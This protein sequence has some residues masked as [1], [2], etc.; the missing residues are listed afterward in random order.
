MEITNHTIVNVCS[1]IPSKI[2]ATTSSEDY[3]FEPCLTDNPIVLPMAATAIKEIHSKS[4]IFADG[5]L[6]FEPDVKQDMYN[7]LKIK[8]GEKILNQIEIMNCIISGK[9]SDIAF[10]IN[11]KSKGYFE[12]VYGIYV[13]LKQSNMYDISMRVA[14]AIEYRHK[15]FQ[16]GII[17]TQ[18][19]LTD[20]FQTDEKDK[21]IMKQET[22]LKEKEE[23]IEAMND[24]VSTL[25]K[26]I[27]ELTEMVAQMQTKVPN[28]DAS[29]EAQPEV[30]KPRGRKP[31]TTKTN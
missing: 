25:Q 19:E 22:L 2:I 27:K 20:T 9:K 15:E 6:T 1:Y 23:E 30:S 4:R 5:W 12:R 16:Q 10:L 21:T 14:K 13:A 24:V 3:V 11:I 26:Q 7:F 8:D 29:S 28:V 17:N 31:T 18:I